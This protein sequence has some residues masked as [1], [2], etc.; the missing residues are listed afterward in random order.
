MD[1]DSPYRNHEAQA[2]GQPDFNKHEKTTIPL[3]SKPTHYSA[4]LDRK[5]DTMYLVA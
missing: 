4:M 2:Q 5:L 1:A 3:S